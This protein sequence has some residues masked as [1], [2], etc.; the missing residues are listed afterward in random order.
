MVEQIQSAILSRLDK[1][2]VVEDTTDLAQASAE[3]P[4][5]RCLAA[6]GATATLVLHS[7]TMARGHARPRRRYPSAH[8]RRSLAWI[9]RPWW[10]RPSPWRPR[11]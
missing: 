4:A 1:D 8:R 11:R 9:A 10:A 2:G 6:V 5:W 7:A 3:D